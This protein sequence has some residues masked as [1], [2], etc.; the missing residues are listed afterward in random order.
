MH[1]IGL[2]VERKR[3]IAVTSVVSGI[4]KSVHAWDYACWKIKRDGF[5]EYLVRV[6]QCVCFFYR[7]EVNV[8]LAILLKLALFM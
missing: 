1:F 3:K 8:A 4:L 6:V 5:N 2:N 7:L